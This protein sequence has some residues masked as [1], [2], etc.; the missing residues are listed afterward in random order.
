[1]CREQADIMYSVKETPRNI[2]CPT[3]SDEM[4]VKRAVR[5]LERRFEC[6]VPDRNRHTLEVRESVPRQ[7][8]GHAK[9]QAE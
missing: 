4:N 5:Y 6:K 2:I 1:M 9:A 8:L 7:R 3:E